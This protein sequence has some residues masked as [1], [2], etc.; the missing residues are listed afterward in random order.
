MMK[1]SSQRD[2]LLRAAEEAKKAGC[3]K[4]Q[5]K[6]FFEA[7]YI[8]QPQQWQFHAA[9]RAADKPDGPT[10]I[11][12][13]GD[14]GGAKSHAI[15]AQIFIDDMQRYPGIYALYLRKVGKAARKALE[16]IRAKTFG[17]LPHRFNSNDGTV[18]YPN[19]SS[20]VIG[21]FRTESDIDKYVGLEF[22][23]M[24]LEEAT[25]L[26]KTAVDLL[27]GSNRSNLPHVRPR[28][29]FGANPG[30]I[31]HQWFKQQFVIPH[32]QHKQ[33]ETY[34]I[35]VSWRQ[36]AFISQ[37][38]INYL[39]SLTGILREIWRD[40]NWDVTAGSF[41]TN[42]SEDIHVIEPFEITPDMPA[43]A[44]MDYGYTHPTA[45]YF[46]VAWQGI[47]YTVVEHCHAR[48]LPE[49]HAEKIH[50]LSSQVL[51]RPVSDLI[52]FVAGH[53]IF[54]QR[55]DAE[56]RTVADQY[57]AHGIHL[58]RANIDRQAGA[59]EMLKRL[60]SKDDGIPPTWYIFKS[61]TQLIKTMPLMQTDPRRP[62]DVLKM[63]ASET[64][65]GDDPYDAARYGIMERP[66]QAKEKNEQ[67]MMS[68]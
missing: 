30:G 1:A 6:R 44:S 8:P 22:P 3:P 37:A 23:I 27:F 20:G 16:Q 38:Y 55:C 7:G 43:W 28:G 58:S 60:G 24:A 26:P 41:F 64:Q 25:Q 56:G 17:T 48:R 51:K 19:G 9:A 11:A 10:R 34:F 63:D 67:F 32:R 57:A 40:G 35:P 4:S 66:L 49:W 46:H 36:N 31:G 2:L 5:V 68:Y 18:S 13:G 52:S 65:D 12:L 61:C 29:Y 21:H 45:V 53:D 39:N 50:Q 62:E 47:I 15:I 54:A 59:A 14:R 42:W 33:K